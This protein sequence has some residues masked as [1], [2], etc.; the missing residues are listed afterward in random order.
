MSLKQKIKQ[1]LPAPLYRVVK[2]VRQALKPHRQFKL[3]PAVEQAALARLAQ[4]AWPPAGQRK[5]LYALTPTANLR[6]VGDQAQAVAIHRWLAKHYPGLPVIEIDKDVAIA[7]IETIAAQTSKDDLIFLHSGGNMGNRGLWSETARRTIIAGLPANQIVSLPQ[8]I[9]FSDTPEGRYERGKSSTI[10]GR[11][12][13]LT[14]MGRDQISGKLAKE[15][16]PRANV[17]TMPDFVLSLSASDFVPNPPPIRPGSVMACLRLDDESAYDAE[18]RARI[19][20]KLGSACTVFDTTLAEQIPNERREPVLRETL[21]LFAGHEA[22]VTDRFHGLI[23]AVLCRKPTV[24]LRTVDHKLTSAFDWFAGIANV[25]FCDDIEELPA[26]LARVKAIKEVD[27]PDFNALYF[28]RL[29]G[30]VG[31]K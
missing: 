8:T 3:N 1:H 17:I 18:A 9:Y 6:N 4:I 14:V 11:H 2:G 20:S 7:G 21:E 29:P 30:L 22:V 13:H 5:I 19:V 12:Q 26:L 25:Q 10:Y 16:F 28:D 27:Y 24:V 23:F 15:I 31:R